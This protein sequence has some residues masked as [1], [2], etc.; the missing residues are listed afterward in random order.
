MILS[1][2]NLRPWILTKWNE[3]YSCQDNLTKNL[4]IRNHVKPWPLFDWIEQNW[5]LL[6]FTVSAHLSL[7]V[8]IRWG[9]IHS[10]IGPTSSLWL[11]VTLIPH[12]CWLT[13]ILYLMPLFLWW[14]QYFNNQLLSSYAKMFPWQAC[15]V[16][17]CQIVHFNRALL[18]VRL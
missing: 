1:N 13:F 5:K 10:F 11:M 4:I 6:R 8:D 17:S 2:Y 7:T 14:V 15:F 3:I 16:L 9:P 12:M 18:L